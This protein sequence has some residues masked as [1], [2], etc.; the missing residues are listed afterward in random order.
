MKP[1]LL[2]LLP[3]LTFQAC[4][5]RTT[6]REVPYA[7]AVSERRQWNTDFY[8]PLRLQHLPRHGSYTR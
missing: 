8:D 6:F 3:L 2:I 1:F 4:A 5:P 7:W